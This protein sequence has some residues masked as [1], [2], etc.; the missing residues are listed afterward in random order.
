MKK[1]A[2][3]F[4]HFSNARHDR[5]LKRVIKDLGPEGYGLYFM[6]LEVLRE[7]IDY[8]YPLTDID[9]LAEEFKTTE[10]KLN[11]IIRHYNLFQ[12]DERENFISLKLVFYLQPYIEKSNRAR[13]A[14]NTR[15]EKTKLLIT[16]ANALHE[17]CDS[18][19]NAM[20]GEERRGEE[21]KGEESKGVKGRFTP[22]TLEEIKNYCLE[23]KNTIDP[24]R[25]ID[26]YESNGWM[27][28]KSKMK[29]WQATIRSW[30][31]REKSN[32]V[33]IKPKNQNFKQNTIA[34]MDDIE[35]KEI[36]ARKAQ[37]RQDANGAAFNKT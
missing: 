9:L 18:T 19:T 35:L 13:V 1:D 25:F 4:P 24:Q 32:K 12:I 5:K 8:R 6:L 23:R 14:A 16:D 30:E 7:Q 10:V 34:S 2:Y 22:P 26:Y 21:S 28:G 11:A 37:R 3:F 27:I 36:L 33:D 29:N 20:Q 15:W 17:H 31:S